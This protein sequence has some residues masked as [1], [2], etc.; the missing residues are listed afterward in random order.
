[1]KYLRLILAMAFACVIA[2]ACSTPMDPYPQPRHEDDD[3]PPTQGFAAHN[4]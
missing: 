1:M 4:L 3:P 2:A